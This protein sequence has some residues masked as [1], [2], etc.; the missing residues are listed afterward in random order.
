MDPSLVRI[1]KNIAYNILDFDKFDNSRILKDLLFYISFSY[2]SDLFGFGEL[3]PKKFSQVM[4]LDYANLFRTHPEPMQLLVSEERKQ[5]LIKNEKQHGVFSKHKLWT[6]YLENALYILMTVPVMT[7]YISPSKDLYEISNFIILENVSVSK[8][9][10]RGQSK[11]IYK[12]KLNKIFVSNLKKFFLNADMKAYVSLKKLNLESPFISFSNL[13]QHKISKGQCAHRFK[14]EELRML[15]HI[16][17]N[18][19]AK[20]IKNKINLKLQKLLPVFEGQYQGFK[21]Q[22]T[23]GD[24]QKYAYVPY[25][26]WD[27]RNTTEIAEENRSIYKQVFR[28]DL[29]HDLLEFYRYQ[30]FDDVIIREHPSDEESLFLMWLISEEDMENKKAIYVSVWGK[31]NKVGKYLNGEK[32]AHSFFSDLMKLQKKKDIIDFLNKH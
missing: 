11:Y 27:K 2:Q 7:N 10:V 19:E 26:S 23:T 21:F 18:L 30:H 4:S 12:Y 14:F 8:I 24:G 20:N 1:D 13:I 22:W 25:I 3:D 6:S 16:S 15:L 31:Y 28:N 32:F 29:K 17:E 9:S 5:Q